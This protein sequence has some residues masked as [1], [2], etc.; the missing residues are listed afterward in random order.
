M[1]N[2]NTNNEDFLSMLGTIGVMIYFLLMMCVSVIPDIPH[3]TEVDITLY[4]S[5]FGIAG[6]FL[7]LLF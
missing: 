6:L 2:K 5:V 3:A 1:D 4:A 7:L